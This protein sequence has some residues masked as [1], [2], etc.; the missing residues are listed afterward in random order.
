VQKKCI[1]CN[2]VYITDDKDEVLCRSCKQSDPLLIEV[3]KDS[4]TKVQQFVEEGSETMEVPIPE[5]NR[6]VI[7]FLYSSFRKD[8]L[9]K[10]LLEGLTEITKNN[11]VVVL[12]TGVT[13]TEIFG[14]Q[15]VGYSSEKQ[16]IT[17]LYE[18]K[19]NMVVMD[20]VPEY[21][22]TMTKM[23]PHTTFVYVSDYG[24]FNDI[25][26]IQLNDVVILRHVEVK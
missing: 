22:G 9:E 5:R 11:A 15:V 25:V 1:H 18:I 3:Y 20:E 26:F 8:K 21:Y 7:V 6:H 23:F 2:A 16:L 10:I 14:A 12:T 4:K 24:N 19:P 17:L 13:S